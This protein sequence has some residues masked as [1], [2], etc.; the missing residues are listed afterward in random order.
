MERL[1]R[2]WKTWGALKSLDTKGPEMLRASAKRDQAAV[3]QMEQ[4]MEVN[5]AVTSE[6]A[7]KLTERVEALT[8]QLNARRE[9]RTASARAKLD[10]I[11]LDQAAIEQRAVDDMLNKWENTLSKSGGA[12]PVEPPQAK[13]KQPS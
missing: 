8:A 4:Q 3:E 2:L 7:A 13:P 11:K 9:A 10:E 12:V 6:L 1:V 5:R